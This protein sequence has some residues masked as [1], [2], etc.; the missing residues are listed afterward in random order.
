MEKAHSVQYN[1]NEQDTRLDDA[2]LKCH[3]VPAAHP[4]SP[5]LTFLYCS[6]KSLNKVSSRT[7]LAD[8]HTKLALLTAMRQASLRTE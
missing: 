8:S 2:A 6:T 3:F 7:Q 4:P 1:G 5:P